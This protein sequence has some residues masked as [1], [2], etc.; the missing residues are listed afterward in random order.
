MGAT[1]SLGVNSYGLMFGDSCLMDD[2]YGLDQGV[3]ERSQNL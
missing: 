2:T 1:V 3:G